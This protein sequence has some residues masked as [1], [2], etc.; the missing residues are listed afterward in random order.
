MLIYDKGS[1]AR[2]RKKRFATDG[3]E[4]LHC[5]L[6]TSVTDR[7]RVI[8]IN[9]PNMYEIRTWGDEFIIWICKESHAGC[10]WQFFSLSK[11]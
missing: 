7:G 11:E 8:K 1:R 10:D 9:M 6:C 3:C 5:A 4:E 2:K